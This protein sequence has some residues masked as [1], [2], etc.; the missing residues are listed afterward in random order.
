MWAWGCWWVIDLC[1]KRLSLALIYVIL[2]IVVNNYANR[3]TFSKA[4]DVWRRL[5]RLAWQVLDIINT[6]MDIVDQ[7][8]SPLNEFRKDSWRLL[9]R[10][11]KPDKKGIGIMHLSGC[12]LAWTINWC[13]IT[14]KHRILE[15]CYCNCHWFCYHGFYRIFCKVNSH[16]HQQY[17]CGVSLGMYMQ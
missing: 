11:T 5:L 4:Y 13:L 12:V 9:K 3:L 6:Q 15:D 17:Y 14:F 2:Y 10:C 16:P 8:I 1:F 7:V